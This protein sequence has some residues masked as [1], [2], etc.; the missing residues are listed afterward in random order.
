[1]E[2]LFKRHLRDIAREPILN[3]YSDEEDE[4]SLTKLAEFH[5]EALRELVN[6]AYNHNSFYHEKMVRQGVKPQDIN[7]LDDLA[8]LPF[9]TKDELRGNPWALLACDKKDVALIHV[10]TG[11][12][13]GEEIYIMQT[14]RDYYLNQFPYGHPELFKLEPDDICI[15]A[16]PYEMSSAGLKIH[17]VF[18]EVNPSSV[19]PAGKGGAYSTPEKTVQVMRDLQPTMV[20]TTPSYAIAIAEAAA[21]VSFDL[22]SLP[23]RKIWLT[24]EGC[25]PAFRERVEK[26][27]GTKANLLYG[28]L[29][30]GAIGFDCDAHAGYHVPL[31]HLIVEVIDPVTGKVLEPGEVGEIVATPL[32]RFDTPLIRYRTQD[33][34]YIDPDPCSCGVVLPRFLL[35]GRLVDQITVRGMN[36]SPFY[37]EEFL[38]RLPEVGNWYQFVVQPG[39]NDQLKI[40]AELAAGVEPTPELAEKLASKMEFAT[41]IPCAFEFVVLPRTRQKSIRVVHE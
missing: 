17:Q 7:S 5:A 13:G 18:M 25:S 4:L 14:W 40:R 10:S 31:G 41:G 22:S 32:L 8:K 26:L 37:L 39:N 2:F 19:V 27:W 30:C 21:E 23:L 16:V 24:G 15:N 20:M 11:T 28:S 3:R 33:L 12:T 29:E 6:R 38:M 34:G 36:F 9:T 35:R 1:M